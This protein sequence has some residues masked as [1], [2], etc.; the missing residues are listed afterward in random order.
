MPDTLATLGADPFYN[1]ISVRIRAVDGTVKKEVYKSHKI[2]S[3]YLENGIKE[4]QDNAFASMSSLNDF[5]MP[6]TV[7]MTG[8][9]IF[10]NSKVF[11]TIR[12]DKGVIKEALLQDQWLAGIELE[13]GIYKIEDNA[14]NVISNAYNIQT[15]ATE[16]LNVSI[17][18][19]VTE[20]GTTAIN[21]NSYV[22]HKSSTSYTVNKANKLYLTIRGVTGNI[23]PELFKNNLNAVQVTVAENI[24]NIGNSAFEG[25]TVSNNLYF[26]CTTT[27]GENAF[28]SANIKNFILGSGVDRILTSSFKDSK[29]RSFSSN[30]KINIIEDDAF[31][32]TSN[33][34]TITVTENE[35]HGKGIGSI[36][37]NAFVDNLNLKTVNI[38]GDIGNIG[39]SA[40][41]NSAALTSVSVT[42]NIGTIGNSAFANSKALDTFSLGGS[43]GEISDEAFSECTALTTFTHNGGPTSIGNRAFFNCMKLKAFDNNEGLVTIG[44]EAFRS[45]FVLASMTAP[46]TL[47]SIG[48]YAFC[49]C[50]VLPEFNVPYGVTK[51]NKY[52]FSG[53]SV[54][55]IKLPLSVTEIDDYAYYGCVG[56]DEL[57]LPSNVKRIG[58]HSFYGCGNITNLNLPQ[59]LEHIGEYAFGFMEKIQS[60]TIPDSVTEMEDFAF[61]ECVALENVTLGSGIMGLNDGVFYDCPNLSSVYALYDLSYISDDN[62]YGACDDE[63]KPNWLTFY[64]IGDNTVVKNYAYDNYFN[65]V[66]LSAGVTK[67][68]INNDSTV[69]T[70]DADLLLKHLSGLVSLSANQLAAAKVNNDDAIDLLDVIEILN[71]KA[72]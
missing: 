49:D 35:E 48:S 19:T 33:L 72:A 39:N 17:P 4:I 57:I 69:N 54:L 50:K 61:Y 64:C 24:N 7:E 41:A 63:R 5:S 45:C 23:Q 44:D 29:I 40:F 10:N 42:G 65:Y 52:T 14:L 11:L 66:D 47:R 51:I 2:S 28:I 36:G 18:D 43:I 34:T 20:V 71:I 27:T 62:F 8:N 32:Y 67:G 30:G 70:E 38:T 55:N 37:N 26:Y 68:D 21:A 25:I 53:C 13:D 46:D 58:S 1:T 31:R 59:N 56:E 3:V 22:Y 6:D 60:L 15:L 9:E 16:F 12:Y